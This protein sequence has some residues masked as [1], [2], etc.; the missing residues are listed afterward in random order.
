MRRRRKACG[1]PAAENLLLV[2]QKG[3]TMGSMEMVGRMMKELPKKWEARKEE[4]TTT[5]GQLF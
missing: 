3:N 1:V 5:Q 4:G 2:S